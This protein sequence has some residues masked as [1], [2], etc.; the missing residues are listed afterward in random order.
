MTQNNKLRKAHGKEIFPDQ[1]E[2]P[3]KIR[4]SSGTAAILNLSNDRLNVKPTTAY[5]MTYKVGKCT[6]NCAFCPQARGSE[7]GADLLSRVS[8]PIYPTQ[9]VIAALEEAVRSQEIGRVCIQGINYPSVFVHISELVKEIKKHARASI[10]VSCQPLKAENILVLKEAGADRLG[11]ALDA[12]TSALF[13][14]IKG[15]KAGCPYDWLGQFRLLEEALKIF[16]KGKVSTHIIAGMG[17]TEKDVIELIQKCVDMTVLPALF[18]FTPIHGAKMENNS[19]PVL[20]SYRRLQLG[21]YLL[22]E[23]LTRFENMNFDVEDKIT[24]FAVPMKDLLR[25]VETGAPFLTSGCSNCNR[26]FYNEKPSGP[27]YNYPR[28]LRHEEIEKIKKQ[29]GLC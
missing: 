8:W 6:A 13:E 17:E 4:V 5:L 28:T 16:G 23:G 7:S 18:A 26:P 19:P 15:N 24:S 29:L 14:N 22:A 25:V 1:G 2:M 27:L 21:R 11:I 10:S 12:A 3:K 9:N 20:E